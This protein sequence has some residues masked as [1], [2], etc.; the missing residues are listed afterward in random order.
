MMKT[1]VVVK[2]DKGKGEV[3]YDDETKVV[4]VIFSDAGEKAVIESYL[5]KEQVFKIPQSQRIDHYK[6]INAKPS[7]ERTYLELALCTLYAKHRIF[8]FWDKEKTLK[9]Q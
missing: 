7:S 3:V 2:S 1:S 9:T 8:V 6:E 5:E 4:D